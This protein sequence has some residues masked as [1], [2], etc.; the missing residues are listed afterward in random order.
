[1]R[2]SPL[3]NSNPSVT[4]KKLRNVSINFT[5][6]WTVF[7]TIIMWPGTQYSRVPFIFQPPSYFKRN[8]FPSC[9]IPANSLLDTS[10]LDCLGREGYF[11]RGSVVPQGQ[12]FSLSQSVDILSICRTMRWPPKVLQLITGSAFVLW[13]MLRK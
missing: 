10:T 12:I 11:Q 8:F 7:W 5:V 13:L 1:M 2:L 3:H 6:W 4:Q 9:P